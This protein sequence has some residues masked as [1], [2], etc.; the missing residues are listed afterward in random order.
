MI[1]L[2]DLSSPS[3][4]VEDANHAVQRKPG[5]EVSIVSDYDC[6]HF[7]SLSLAASRRPPM[8]NVDHPIGPALSG[9]GS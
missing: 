7:N 5:V 3:S 1:I 8:L 2:N 9:A 4:G 6:K